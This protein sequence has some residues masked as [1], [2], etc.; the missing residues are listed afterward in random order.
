MYS[1]QY[2]LASKVKAKLTKE[3]LNPDAN[4]RKLV[5]NANMLDSLMESI[6]KQPQKVSFQPSTKIEQTEYYSSSSESSEEEWSDEEFMEEVR[7]SEV[8]L[9][10]DLSDSE[11]EEED[12][13][14]SLT[15]RKSE[16]ISQLSD[17][18]F[19]ITGQQL[20]HLPMLSHSSSEDEDTFSDEDEEEE[21]YEYE[22]ET[23]SIVKHNG[24]AVSQLNLVMA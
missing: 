14:Y 17:L 19:T 24:L 7:Q 8:E 1:Q 10:G 13:E 23:P 20:D 9:V 21:E 2:L 3:A 5:C 4:L 22:Y 12:D 16:P 11:D 15:R 6:N 18:G